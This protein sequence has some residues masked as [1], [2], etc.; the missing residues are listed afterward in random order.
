MDPVQAVYRVAPVM[1]CFAPSKAFA[2]AVAALEYARQA[3]DGFRV[4]Y[5]VW[6]VLAG[7]LTHL[8]TFRPAPA[9]A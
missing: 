3:A 1:R 2:D 4:G 9:R 5:A 7:R 8:E 6:R